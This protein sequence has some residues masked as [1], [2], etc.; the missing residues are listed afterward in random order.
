MSLGMKDRGYGR[1]RGKYR[2]QLQT[3]KDGREKTCVF[4]GVLW[5]YRT[6]EGRLE[7]P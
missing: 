3:I 6:L 1:R 7:R 5:L 2:G 4:L